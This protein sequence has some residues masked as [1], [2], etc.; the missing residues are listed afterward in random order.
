[1]YAPD[2]PDNLKYIAELMI[3]KMQEIILILSAD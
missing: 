1:M 3:E 2:M